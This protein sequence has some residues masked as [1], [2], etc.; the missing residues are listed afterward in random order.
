MTCK[1]ETLKKQLSTCSCPILQ[2]TEKLKNWIHMENLCL[3]ETEK[4][5]NWIHMENLCLHVPGKFSFSVSPEIFRNSSGN[6]KTEKLKNWKTEKLNPYG[7]SL[8]GSLWKKQF[9][10]F[11]VFQFPELFRNISGEIEKL[12]NWI[13]QGHS[14]R[15]SPYGFSF[16]VFQ[17]LRKYSEIVPE[18]EK[19]KNWKTEKLNPY[20]ESLPGSLWK[21]SFSVFQFLELFRNISGEIEKLKNWIFQGHS[22]RGSPYGF[23]FLVFQFFSFRNYFGIFPEKLKNWIHMENLC[24]NVPGKFSFS[25]FQFLRKYSEI[26]P[27]TEKLNPYGESLPGS[28]WKKQFFSFS[29]L[30]PEV[31]RNSSGT[32]PKWKKLADDEVHNQDMLAS[33]TI[34]L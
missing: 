24:L 5:K 23:S 11:S 7:E 9:F 19:L 34:C 16:S 4:L 31:F 32:F 22:G 27:E 30:V 12:K 14:G 29:V 8:P 33:T 13:F 25:V 3:N 10:S 21:D 18:T 1:E 2:K 20:G 26:V 15:D 6:W 17:F 28:L